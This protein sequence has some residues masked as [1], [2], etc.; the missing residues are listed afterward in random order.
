M[1]P[2]RVYASVLPTI[3][4]TVRMFWITPFWNIENLSKVKVNSSL[5]LFCVKCIISQLNLKL[6]YIR[7]CPLYLLIIRPQ[8]SNPCAFNFS[9]P[10]FFIRRP[11]L[12]QVLSAE[13]SAHI[14]CKRSTTLYYLKLKEYRKAPTLNVW[15]TAVESWEAKSPHTFSYNSS[16]LSFPIAPGLGASKSMASIYLSESTIRLVD[17]GLYSSSSVLSQVF[18][19]SVHLEIEELKKDTTIS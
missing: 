2:V 19:S 10:R 16:P 9:T 6:L 14:F 18:R 3:Y 12:D 13:T 7:L 17:W 15:G 8:F 1:K 11:S 4:I 5:C